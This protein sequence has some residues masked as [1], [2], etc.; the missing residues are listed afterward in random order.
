MPVRPHAIDQPLANL[1]E[2]MAASPSAA[3]ADGSADQE[4]HGEDDGNTFGE[5]RVALPGEAGEP[6]DAEVIDWDAEGETVKVAHDPKLPSDAEVEAHRAAGHWPFRRWCIHCVAARG[7]G[8]Q[9]RTKS[10][11]SR[12]RE[13]PVIS[14]DYFFLTGGERA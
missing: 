5:S 8:M 6:A 4:N 2:A 1:E 7:L 10:S 14:I 3:A 12:E 9:H 11:G 13:I